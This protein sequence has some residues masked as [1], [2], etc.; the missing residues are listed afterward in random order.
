MH[1]TQTIDWHT[2]TPHEN[3]K[4]IKKF[5]QFEKLS[6]KKTMTLLDDTHTLLGPSQKIGLVPKTQK[7]N[8]NRKKRKIEY[9]YQIWC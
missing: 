3:P 8:K 9:L 1:L 6:I 7:V 2:S 4:G 5:N